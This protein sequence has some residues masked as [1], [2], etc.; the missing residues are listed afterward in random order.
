MGHHLYY[1]ESQAFFWCDYWFRSPDFDLTLA[2]PLCPFLEYDIDERH[3]PQLCPGCVNCPQ[4]EWGDT[5]L[6]SRN[7]SR[8]PDEDK[9]KLKDE[10]VMK[11][12]EKLRAEKRR[13]RSGRQGETKSVMSVSTPEQTSVTDRSRS[14]HRTSAQHDR[15]SSTDSNRSNVTV[16]P[17]I[18]MDTQD[19]REVHPAIPGVKPRSSNTRARVSWTRPKSRASSTHSHSESGDE[20]EEQL[21]KPRGR[22]STRPVTS[23]QPEGMA[24]YSAAGIVWQ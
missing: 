18:A 7:R 20:T 9:K 11:T 8:I 23:L 16:V 15:S 6:P 5:W 10:K 12:V 14:S 13:Q 3:K 22:A 21:R 24:R 1:Q 19:S 17:W 4:D 2:V